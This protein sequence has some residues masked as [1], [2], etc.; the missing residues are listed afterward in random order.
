MLEASSVS[1]MP[2][3]SCVFLFLSFLFMAIS[4]S[5]TVMLYFDIIQHQHMMAS[6]KVVTKPKIVVMN[7]AIDSFLGKYTAFHRRRIR[8][9]TNN[10]RTTNFHNIMVLQ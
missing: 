5:C 7:E 2:K 8:H 4:I 6:E 10:T 1:N 3:S 9:P